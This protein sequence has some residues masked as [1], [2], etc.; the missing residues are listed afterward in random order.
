MF[1]YKCSACDY[2][3]DPDENDGVEFDTLPKEWEC[4][5]CGAEK[6]QFIA[7]ESYSEESD[8]EEAEI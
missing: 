2:E 8:A 4:T 3:Y 1:Y 5:V 6:S 7:V